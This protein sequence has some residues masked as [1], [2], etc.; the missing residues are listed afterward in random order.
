MASLSYAP[1][2]NLRVEEAGWSLFAWFGRACDQAAGILLSPLV[3]AIY[4]LSV[5]RDPLRL[6]WLIATF[7]FGWM[8]GDTVTPF[9][10]RLTVRVM[11]W[12]V[13][14]YIVRLSAVLLLFVA[15][16][17]RTSPADERFKSTTICFAAYAIATGISR[18][19]QA[20]HVFHGSP[21]HLWDARRAVAF[22][23]MAAVVGIAAL[24]A[25]SVLSTSS[26]AWSRSFGRVFALAAAALGVAT[27]AAVREATINPELPARAR[28]E[29]PDHDPR[30]QSLILPATL[31][32]TGVTTLP[33]VEAMAF[34]HLFEQFRRQAI[35]VRGAAAFFVAGWMIG[36]LVWNGLRGRVAPSTLAQLAVGCGALGLLV[37]I[38]TTEVARSDWFPATIQG[39]STVS[40]LIYLTGGLVGL[41]TSG[42]RLMLADVREAGAFHAGWIAPILAGVASLAPILGGWA[43][44][45]VSRDW[46]LISG[47]IL[48]ML[49]LTLI[50]VLPGA[51]DRRLPRSHA[52]RSPTP[53]FLSRD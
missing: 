33:F 51:S 29:A 37:A 15:V 1:L 8:L 38:A 22:V 49:L 32:A 9:L 36:L 5:E 34:L 3:L 20:R 28:R 24:A 13:G 12:I 2:R 46:V 18:S 17:S 43:A 48:S 11:P 45:E 53:A 16:T 40:I 23:G 21:Y 30:R 19:A 41:A 39:R 10:H 26:M 42:R 35:Y 14:G 31:V 50:G 44:T 4:A 47:V 52:G 6:S 7:G 25:W 27:L